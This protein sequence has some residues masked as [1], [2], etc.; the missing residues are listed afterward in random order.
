MRIL[1]V[2]DHSGISV[3]LQMLLE[4]EGF[5][6]AAVTSGEGALES[7]QSRACDV[8]LLDLHT[9]GMTAQEFMREL[10]DRAKTAKSLRP[11][12][13]VMSASQRIE[14]ESRMIGADFTI[15]K[16]FDHQDLVRRINS[17]GFFPSHP[18]QL[19]ISRVASG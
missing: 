15:R 5:E 1:I 3:A 8:I 11:V 4:L 13:G 16:P 7:L 19:D 12:V 18:E 14:Q 17:F 9:D 6:V 10:D 2:E